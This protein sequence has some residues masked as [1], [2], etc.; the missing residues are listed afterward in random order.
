MFLNIYKT[1]SRGPWLGLILSLSLLLLFDKG[2]VRKYLA[3]I[4]VI[5]VAVFV[6]RPGV[7]DTILNIYYATFDLRSPLGT[8]YEY[9][10]VLRGLAVKTVSKDMTREL[11]GYG[12]EAFYYL[13]L[14]GVLTGKPS[15]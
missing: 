2:R 9:R 11:W 10:Y 6:I 15:N 4:G 3:V 14:K 12:M 5:I 13:G 7:L 1:S 8:S